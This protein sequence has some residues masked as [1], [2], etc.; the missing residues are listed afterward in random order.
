MRISPVIGFCLAAAAGF[1]SL[2]Q[3]ADFSSAA[4][5][6]T[7]ADFLNLG[8]GARAAGMGG[9]YAAVADDATA[10]YWNPAALTAIAG[11]SI[12]LMH[13]PY[14]AS[15]Y[16]DYAGYGQ[17]LGGYGAWGLGFEYFSAGSIDQT[18]PTG[19]SVGSFS[20]YD[21]AVS[22][23]YAY[24]FDGLGFL[25]GYSLGV[26]GKFIESGIMTTAQTEAADL[27]LLSPGYFDRRLHW[28]LTARN[29]GPALKFDQAQEN[30]P[31]AFDLG[32]AYEIVGGWIVSADAAAPRGGNPYFEA[33]TEYRLYQDRVWSFYGRAGYDSETLQSVTGF[34]GAAFGFGVGYGG[35]SV[36][37][38]FVPMGGVGQAHRIS[39]GY[40]FGA[41]AAPKPPPKSETRQS[42]SPQGM[43]NP[44]APAPDA[45]WRGLMM[46]D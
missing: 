46:G 18:D 7:A 11:K 23:G 43:K 25:D 42:P 16:F 31:A 5:G 3:A 30:L 41:A 19:A 22:L 45:G 2:G 33:G 39:L 32:A 34:S 38:A 8:V 37:Y 21:L 20:P 40:A 14:I 13:A 27:G 28:A 12:S 1:S 9:A 35:L 24:R 36:D 10:L 29:L 17:N 6:T 26:A 4:N 44:P 15:S